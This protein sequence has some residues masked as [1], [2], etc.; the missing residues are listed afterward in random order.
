MADLKPYVDGQSLEPI[1]PRVY[2]TIEDQ[3]ELKA[4]R[5]FGTLTQLR[6]LCDRYHELLNELKSRPTEAE[7]RA[8]AIDD[9]YDKVL[10]FEDYIEPKAQ[11]H[12]EL[13]YSGR[14]ITYMIRKIAD[15]LKEDSKE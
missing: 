14:D 4:Y 7:I 5:E 12:A 13:M 8:K 9:F 1:G 15:Q 11:I 2:T 6:V 10:N 3:A